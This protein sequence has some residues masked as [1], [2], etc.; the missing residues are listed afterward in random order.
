MKQQKPPFIYFYRSARGPGIGCQPDGS[1]ERKAGKLKSVT[2]FG[3][4]IFWGVVEYPTAL[5]PQQVYDYELWPHSEV[6][7]AIWR[8]WEQLRESNNLGV[9]ESYQ[10][11]ILEDNVEDNKQEITLSDRFAEDD[12]AI[13]VKILIENDIG[14]EELESI[15][16]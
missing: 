1:N 13:V 5:H 14:I 4:G 9:Y 2:P 12:T 3:T 8:A 6:Q 15:L 7:F 10:A 16:G 11:A